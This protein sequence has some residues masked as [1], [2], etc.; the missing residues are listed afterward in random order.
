M[1]AVRKIRADGFTLIELMITIAIFAITL[2][3]GVSSYRSWVLNNQ[4][5]NAAESI[6]NGIMLARAEAVKCNANVAFTIGTGSSWTVTHTDAS[7]PAACFKPGP[8][9]RARKTSRSLLHRWPF[10]PLRPRTPSPSTTSG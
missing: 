7:P 1:S 6:S 5:R 4:I 8:A 3:F 9:A 10:H 2:T